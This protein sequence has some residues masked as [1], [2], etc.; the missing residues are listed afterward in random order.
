MMIADLAAS[1]M[2][3]QHTEEEVD[4]IRTCSRLSA[5]NVNP[6]DLP[7]EGTLWDDTRIECR[8]SKRT[9]HLL[10][11]GQLPAS[12]VPGSFDL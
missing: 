7:P 10:R 12:L 8:S 2:V 6:K 3:A 9:C 5:M 11:L 4:P 1:A